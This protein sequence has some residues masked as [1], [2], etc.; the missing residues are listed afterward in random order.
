MEALVEEI[1]AKLK[2]LKVFDFYKTRALTEEQKGWLEF[3]CDR[4]FNGSPQER[5]KLNSLVSPDISFLFFLYAKT[6]A[7]ESVQ[8][9]DENRIVKGLVSIAIENQTFDGRESL[10]PLSLLYHSAQ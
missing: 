1:F 5:K 6:M 8:E 10:F 7:I 2:L 3:L 9:Q 4:Y